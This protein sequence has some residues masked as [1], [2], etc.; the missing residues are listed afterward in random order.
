MADLPVTTEVS[1][2]SVLLLIPLRICPPTGLH[3]TQL[4]LNRGL[5]SGPV[6]STYSAGSFSRILGPL[7]LQEPVNLI[8]SRHAASRK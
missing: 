7:P 5:L 6:G 8:R 2:V 3:H 4:W 1:L